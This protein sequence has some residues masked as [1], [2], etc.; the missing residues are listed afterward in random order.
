MLMHLLFYETLLH[1]DKSVKVKHPFI[2]KVLLRM[3]AHLF[4][5]TLFISAMLC[6]LTVKLR[7]H[8]SNSL[9]AKTVIQM[10]FCILDTSL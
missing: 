3:S 5:H 4:L 8:H 9:E 7:Y 1:L 6:W 2:K 10:P